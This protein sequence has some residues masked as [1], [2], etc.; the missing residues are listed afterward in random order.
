[1]KYCGFR[2][3]EGKNRLFIDQK[4]LDAFLKELAKEAIQVDP[5]FKGKPFKEVIKALRRGTFITD[6]E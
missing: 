2:V 1:M 4:N 3:T 5:Q 6:S